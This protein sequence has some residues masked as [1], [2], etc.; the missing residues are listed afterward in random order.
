MNAEQT[1]E[2][3][4]FDLQ[5][6]IGR[7]RYIA[8]GMGLT[9]LAIVPF[10]LSVILLMVSPGIG[11]PVFAIMEIALLVLSVG[12]MVRRLH[13]M[14]KSG[15]WS[16]LVIVPLVNLI[17]WLFLIFAPGSDGEN[18]FGPSPP[19][20]S[21]WVVVGAWSLLIIPFFGGIL[22]A[23]A[24]PAYQDFVA[25][26]QMVEGVQLAA[27]GEAPV[28][29]YFQANKAWPA[30]LASVYPAAKDSPAGRYVASV[31]GSAS[32]DSSAYGIISTMNTT[33]IHY[34]LV[35]KSVEVW[36]VDGGKTWHCGPASSNPVEPR[37]LVGSC[38]DGDAP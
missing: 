14:D 29:E 11:W 26:S 9:L 12:F 10:T 13:D 28:A 27:G 30:D 3:R 34:A 31:S 16:L 33:A 7:L 35:G 17:L 36:T 38:R 15:W 23:I 37:Y 6:R 2:I 19:P 24:I 32:A 8:Y 21:T 1:A 5:S 20:N 25:R 4:F 22:A 18:R